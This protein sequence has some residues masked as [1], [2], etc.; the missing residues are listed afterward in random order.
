MEQ[1]KPG[2]GGPGHPEGLEAIAEGLSAIEATSL[3]SKMARLMPSIEAR[4]AQGVRHQA[5]VAFLNE[6]GIQI[7][8]GTFRS[9]LTRAR[10]KGQGGRAAAGGRPAQ[11]P[12][13]NPAAPATAPA[14]AA[15]PDGDGVSS[16][17]PAAAAVV[18]NKAQLAALRQHEV[19]LEDFAKV[20]KGNK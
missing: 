8:L 7:N 12:A 5:V 13:S 17:A 16:A 11:P 14:K 9:Y 19:N 1:N 20:A 3:A 2:A 15:S 4:L 18:G 6:R 10:K